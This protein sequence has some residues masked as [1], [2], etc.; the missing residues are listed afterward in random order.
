MTRLAE[1]LRLL[2]RSQR[3]VSEV[4]RRIG[5]N[6]QQFGRYLSGAGR[7]SDH[8]LQRICDYFGVTE[9]DLLLDPVELREKL[10]ART[11][12]LR[13][14]AGGPVFDRVLRNVFPGDAHLLK[15]YVGVIQ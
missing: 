4:C 3:S 11:G 1:N 9:A 2:C 6:R 14:A 13:T 8:N 7:P 12:G 5:L 15:R 10:R